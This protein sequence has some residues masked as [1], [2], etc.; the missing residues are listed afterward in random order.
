MNSID[1]FDHG[2]R[3]NP[4]AP[5]L[6]D[7]RTG[8]TSSYAEVRHETLLAANGLRQAG[9]STGKKAA[10]LSYNDPRGYTAVLSIL[11]GG[12][13]WIPVNPRNAVVDNAQILDRFDC[14]VLFFQ[15]QFAELL[16]EIERIAPRISL[17]VC[18]DGDAGGKPSWDAW[19]VDAKADEVEILHDPERPFVIQPTGGTT[20]F[21]KGVVLSNR[22]LENIVA[23]FTA[24][25]PCRGRPVFLAAAPL[26]HAAGQVFQYVL[27]HGGSGIVFPTVDRSALL[28]AIP[29]FGITHA[30]L[31]PTVIYD[32]LAVPGVRERDYSTLQYFFYGASPMAPG[33]LAEALDVFGPVMCQIYGQTESGVPNTFLSSSDHFVGGEIAELNRLTSCG[34]PTPFCR[35]ATMG[36]D[37]EL[38]ADGEVGELVVRGTGVMTEYYKDPDATRAVSEHGWHHTG[39]V[40][41][42]DQ[43]GYFH[44]VDRM[45]DMIISGG[46]NIYSSEVERA[47]LAHPA[48][49]DCAVIGTPDDKWGERVSAVVQLK[50]GMLVDADTL[51]AHCKA[52]IGSMKA[53]KQIDFVDALP[54]SPA[55]KILKRKLKEQY[56]KG[57]TR[58]VS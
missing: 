48:V 4:Q 42:R 26:T 53:P 19:L 3:L 9:Y 23:S 2:W 10:V 45:K 52:A 49:L 20:G 58:M 31:P 32:L 39:D 41:Y 38:L 55:G 40:G 28:D 27:A 57:Q 33:K 22:A 24:V 36:P 7:A 54:R 1:F 29:R 35:V 17:F 15:R 50:E 12:L 43:D 46:F 34:R 8:V 37:G 14:D 47:L 16:P 44:I 18:I 25:A 13:T 56:W 51:I 21:P 6:V 5:C 11:R 30:F